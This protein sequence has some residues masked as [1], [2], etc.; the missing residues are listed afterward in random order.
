MGYI[1]TLILTMHTKQRLGSA[2]L[3]RNVIGA[4][5]ICV[6]TYHIRSAHTNLLQILGKTE[7]IKQNSKNLNYLVVFVDI[8]L[9]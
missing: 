3:K 6:Q 5:Y 4:E 9:V 8:S 7:E 2:T 1:Y